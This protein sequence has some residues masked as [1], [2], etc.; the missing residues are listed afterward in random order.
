M[1]GLLLS[2]GLAFSPQY[3]VSEVSEAEITET[4]EPT[5]EELTE[6]EIE[7]VLQDLIEKYA[8]KETANLV[9]QWALNS[10]ILSAFA[11]FLVKY[12]KVKNKT[13][14]DIEE[15]AKEK[16]EKAFNELFEGDF[17]EIF[18]FIGEN[19]ALNEKLLQA[20]VLSQDKSPEGKIA[21]T[22]LL[23][24]SASQVVKESAER[25]IE[26]VKKDEAK[27]DELKAELQDEVEIKID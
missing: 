27:K 24:E 4:T 7:G 18:K 9:V 15:L 8:N 13:L 20:F 23:S 3:Q 22:Q 5:E 16:L 6:E 17:K 10:G 25:I 1:L 21:L 19:K 11:I 2:I 12:R 14:G 26:D